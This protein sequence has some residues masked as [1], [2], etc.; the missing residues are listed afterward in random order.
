MFFASCIDDS[1]V[2]YTYYQNDLDFKVCFYTEYLVPEELADTSLCINSPDFKYNIIEPHSTKKT[3]TGSNI[4]YQFEV[5]RTRRHYF[6]NYDSVIALPWDRIRE[7]YMVI[8]RID[9][10]SMK[11]Y[12]KCNFTITIP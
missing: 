9:M 1:D 6:F 10:S 5:G 3:L 12:E 4:F 8:K 7:E 11:E 2:S